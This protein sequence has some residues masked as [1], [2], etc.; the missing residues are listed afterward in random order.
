MQALSC[1]ASDFVETSAVVPMD[2]STDVTSQ[3]G[4]GL[5]WGSPAPV[6][7]PGSSDDN[8]YKCAPVKHKVHTNITSAWL[9]QLPMPALQSQ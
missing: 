9:E 3:N 8:H 4:W 6:L 5:G 7:S 2:Q 1:H